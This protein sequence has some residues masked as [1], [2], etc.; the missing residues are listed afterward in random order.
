[1]AALQVFINL[2]LLLLGAKMRPL[3]DFE[4][5]PHMLICGSTG[6]GKTY[7]TAF[8]LAK[9][10]KCEEDISLV[11]CDYK[12]SGFGWL[13]ESGCPA[14]YGY[15]K[16]TDG[17]DAVYNEFS[18]RLRLNDKVRNSKQLFLFIDEYGAYISALDKKAADTVKSKIGEML[19]MGR[20]LGVHLII[21]IQRADASYFY[22][23]AR[24]QFSA[25][26]MLGNLSEEQKSMLVPNY[27]EQ[28]R[29]LNARGQG[30]LYV[31]GS[32]FFRVLVPMVE[33]EEKVHSAIKS[34]MA[35]GL[36]S[37][38]VAAPGLTAGGAVREGVRPPFFAR[39]SITP[40][41][42]LSQAANTN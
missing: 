2:N 34:I 42:L 5:C 40:C 22:A 33:D 9:L 21:G 10:A 27:K 3:L 36:P 20:S 37:A 1:M 14:F 39:V 13:E 16:V 11:V 26:L 41:K 24:D 4:K 38:A 25:I 32:G 31:D 28:M 18:Q 30:Y 15:D 17:I 6:S 12:K 8:L 7:A 29:E 23:G 35:D 19:F